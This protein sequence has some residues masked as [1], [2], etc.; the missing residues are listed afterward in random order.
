MNRGPTIDLIE[1]KSGASI[2]LTYWVESEIGSG[3]TKNVTQTIE[4]GTR[5]SIPESCVDE[6]MVVSLNF[7][8]DLF[9]FR[10][11]PIMG[12]RIIPMSDKISATIQ[13]DGCIRVS[14]C[15]SLV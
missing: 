10:L 8:D 3:S 5:I 2:R 7:R 12:S 1:N 11:N 14:D 13:G 6:F 15:L 4:P 9:K